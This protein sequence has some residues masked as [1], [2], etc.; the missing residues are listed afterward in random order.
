MTVRPCCTPA[1]RGYI[2]T[3]YNKPTRLPI[4]GQKIL[5]AVAPVSDKGGGKTMTSWKKWLSE[6]RH[7]IILAAALAFSGG[8]V[9]ACGGGGGGDGPGPTPTHHAGAI[10]AFGSIFVNGVRFHTGGADITMDGVPVTE[11]KLRVGMMVDVEGTVNPDGVTG[12]AATVTFDDTIQGLVET[13]VPAD[14][15]ITVMG[16]RVFIDD[17]TKIDDSVGGVKTF[18]DLLPNT[19]VQISGALDDVG[20]LRATHIQLRNDGLSEATGVLAGVGTSFTMAGLPNVTIN[21]AGAA[22]D[23]PGATPAAGDLVE[24]KGAF[25]NG[26]FTASSVEIKNVPE[27]E[28]NFHF[29]GFVVSGNASGFV[30]QGSHL[31]KNLAVDTIDT[32][33]FVGGNKADL[34]VGTKVEAQG[35]LVN[36]TLQASK[37][38]FKEN[39]RIEITAGPQVAAE[40]IEL[41]NLSSVTVVTNA[42]TVPNPAVAVTEGDRLR[43]RG[44]MSGDGSKV[45]ATRLENQGA[46]GDARVILRGP[47]SAIGA[48]N[49]SLTI[50]GISVP[51]AGAQFRPNDDAGTGTL[52]I[53][54]TQFFSKVKVGTVVK[55]RGDL[56]ADNLLVA[57]EVEL[58]D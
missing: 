2:F 36:G 8:L 20:N 47:V 9:A 33:I 7:L 44:R 16:K 41:R 25:S 42:L 4:S 57:A 43:I 3:R 51:V 49:S 13:A 58:E 37:V 34:V 50:L 14:N 18:D 55:V 52:F 21:T 17:L 35:K 56:T 30:L 1:I 53:T 38:K 27:N 31:A 11:D 12:T 32:T 40:G 23:P 46:G 6:K 28:A 26:V 15:S 5:E 39:I 10:E 22:I 48:G 19:E 29:E 45:V 24:V 54:P